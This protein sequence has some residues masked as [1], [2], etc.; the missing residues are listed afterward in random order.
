MNAALTGKYI[1]WHLAVVSRSPRSTNSRGQVPA[2]A[3]NLRRNVASRCRI[4]CRR[5]FRQKMSFSRF[6]LASRS[7][8]RRLGRKNGVIRWP[9]DKG[10]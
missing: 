8:L 10:Y 9:A 2:A 7:G 6:Q 5:R 1:D 3:V 4:H